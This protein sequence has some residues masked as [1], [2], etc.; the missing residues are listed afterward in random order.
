M[1]TT[2]A[3][4]VFPPGGVTGRAVSLVPWGT[5]ALL[6]PS[7]PNRAA[8]K[9]TPAVSGLTP[10]TV[11]Q[12]S[13]LGAQRGY[14]AA[15]AD[16]AGNAWL[17]GFAGEVTFLPPTGAG[18]LYSL[19][20]S[21]SGEVFVGAAY[22]S[23][24]PYFAA[25]SGNLYTVSGSAIAQV[26]G[27]FGER[28]DDLA[29]DATHLYG[30]LPASAKL[31]VH[32]LSGGAVTKF[33]TPMAVPAIV[34]ASTSGVAVGGWT[35]STIASGAAALALSPDGGHAAAAS[36]SA[37]RILLL[38]G[39]DPAWAL[40]QAVSGVGSPV[41]VGW[42][43]NGVQ[44]LATDTTNN[45]VRVL[46]LV[47]GALALV[48]Q[49][50]VSGAAHIAMG[51]GSNFALVTQPTRNTVSV[52][53]G[54]SNVWSDTASVAVTNPTAIA[55][56]S[57]TEAAVGSASGV[58]FL[59][60]QNG[61][62]AVEQA[63]SGLPFTPVS[64]S[65]DPLGTVYAAGSAGASGYAA[66]V[67]KGGIGA[68]TS[69]TGSATSVF[70]RQG[71]IAVADAVNSAV[72]VFGQVGSTLTAAAS[73]AAPSGIG[74]IAQTG[75]SVWL[76]GSSALW[77]TRFTAPYRLVPY[78]NGQVSI[79]NG[80][81][82]VTANLG[83][84]HQPSAMVWGPSGIWVATT[85]DDIFVF[86]QTATLQAQQ[87]VLPASPQT[88]GTPL[89]MSALQFLDSGLFAASSLNNGLISLVPA[90]ASGAPVA[91]SNLVLQ[92]VSTSS[93]S[94][95]LAWGA[96]LGTPPFEFQPFYRIGASGSF[97]P[98]GTQTS[99]LSITVSGL[100]GTT[101]YNFAVSGSNEAGS[102]L[103]NIV[104]AQ[105]QASIGSPVLSSTLTSGT[106]LTLNWTV[107]AGVPT[108]LYQVS[109]LQVGISSTFTPIG[110]QITATTLPV[111]NLT[112]GATYQFKV[113]ASNGSGSADS[114]IIQVTMPVAPT[115]PT[116]SV[117]S[118]GNTTANATWT[119]ASGVAPI[120][121]TLT[122]RSGSKGTFLPYGSPTANLSEAVSGLVLGT[123]YQ[124]QLAAANIGGTTLSNIVTLSGSQSPGQVLV[125]L[126][127]L[128][129]TTAQLDFTVPSG[130]PTIYY[131]AALRQGTSGS[132]SLF[133]SPASG[134]TR[135]VVTGLTPSS[136]YSFEVIASNEIG[137]STS[138][139]VSG[140]TS[141]AAGVSG[142]QMAAPSGIS[143][144]M[145]GPTGA[146][147][148]PGTSL[149]VS[150]VRVT[151]DDYGA[152]ILNVNW[153]SETS[154]M[155]V[156]ISG[157]VVSG[158]GGPSGGLGLGY[159]DGFT[160]DQMNTVIATL[161]YT[162]PASGVTSDVITI[163]GFDSNS[164][165]TV[166]ELN[167]GVAVVS[168]SGGGGGGTGYAAY[169]STGGGVSG[170]ALLLPTGYLATQGNQFIDPNNGNLPVR[171]A[172]AAYF[173]ME[174]G[175]GLNDGTDR[176]QP[177]GLWQ[178]NY[179]TILNAVVAM[180]FNAIRWQYADACLAG[181]LPTSTDGSNFTVNTTL[182]PDMAG[183]TVL[184]AIDIMVDYCR[185][186]GLKVWFARMWQT[187]EEGQTG[188][189]YSAAPWDRQG[190]INNMVML[191][192]RYANNPTVF[193]M[194]VN[195]EV[196]SPPCTFGDGVQNTDLRQF[197]IDAGNAILNVN[198]NVLI[199]CQSYQ[200]TEYNGQGVGIGTYDDLSP[201]A[202]APVTLSVP[203]R[204]AFA[205]HTYPPSINGS[206]QTPATWAP[207]WGYLYTTGV[208]PIIITEFG[209]LAS[210]TSAPSMAWEQRI[211]TY[212]SNVGGASGIAGVPS[213]GFPPS[214]TWYDLNASGW[215]Q[216]DG[217][218]PDQG[219]CLLASSNWQTPL[220]SQL[221][222]LPQMMFYA[223]P[224]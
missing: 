67:T 135:I 3:S 77:Q 82:F 169:Q 61:V 69:W 177:F 26:S 110:G 126:S 173:G 178:V 42:A 208:A 36:T 120:S 151:R 90:Q 158:Y 20:G 117:A 202:N 165:P 24:A 21:A 85:Q 35:A 206:T 5:D 53:T 11:P 28:T 58:T 180:G 132:Y 63:V 116:L 192:Q 64:I 87:T 174:T 172:A 175:N 106:G 147:L 209:R 19:P 154:S 27:G 40:T 89:G 119:A 138:A 195:N 184:G 62:W 220:A 44:V 10:V 57:D 221:N 148:A 216:G 125:T 52:L 37:G 149:L 153:V 86:D 190:V 124:F 16:G 181:M 203:G 207:Q 163:D 170:Q 92:V 217:Y 1:A 49:I 118:T 66:I 25:S 198:P 12:V 200:V 17:L 83:V 122:L 94:A 223:I 31:G 107:P 22:S 171:I 189:F 59:S 18:T 133:G 51:Q 75:V 45:A 145:A 6:L 129:S 8:L 43:A 39:D 108:I 111:G 97:T 33:S 188:L 13:G 205:I 140:T 213:N 150:G 121:Y 74:A 197:W 139:A 144:Y 137:S 183:Q 113:T 98:F 157:A 162:A 41:D 210:D 134:V 136:P 34:A 9:F 84:E 101:T 127:N 143:P 156:I 186:I 182:N 99:A 100:A 224:G 214:M 160:I 71:Q 211:L 50:T 104:S 201:V 2:Q 7:W 146:T 219:F 123:Q 60:V 131:Q 114:N 54:V 76:C 155:S 196:S 167:I 130:T 91:P 142:S 176:S 159:P 161:T 193:A 103:S 14:V 109:F 70:Y 55:L 112:Q 88:A 29:G 194:E 93:Q 199:I 23:G 152:I 191:A 115:A 166:P 79:F 95:N 32:A 65:L 185:Q 30:V 102:T 73:G 78:L 215:T 72:R 204:L 38:T 187:P 164:P 218:A 168:G 128:T 46:D 212:C 179:K 81:S 141:I 105:T 48:Q 56:L 80:S 222:L 47:G 68:E 15:E 96:P 4:M